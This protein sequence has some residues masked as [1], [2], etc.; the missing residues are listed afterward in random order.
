MEPPEARSCVINWYK[1]LLDDA[2][3]EVAHEYEVS[4]DR[5]LHDMS[6]RQ[7]LAELSQ[8][9]LLCAM[10][11]AL[12]SAGCLDSAPETRTDLYQQV[13][14]ALVFRR[15]QARLAWHKD[16]SM[17]VGRERIQV[18]QAIARTMT[19]KSLSV[20]PIWRVRPGQ[21]AG[22]V[23]AVDVVE[24]RLQTMPTASVTAHE[25]LSHLVNRSCVF[26][27][28]GAGEGQFVHRTFQE[29]LAGQEYAYIEDIDTLLD[30]AHLPSW[31][32]T[33]VFAA[34]TCGRA[35]ASRL[36]KGL[37]ALA[38]K[39][40]PERRE[41]LILMAECIGSAGPLDDDAATAARALVPEV[42]PPRNHA[43]GESI[44]SLGDELVSWLG[45]CDIPDIEALRASLHAC[46]IVGSARAMAVVHRFSQRPEAN[47]AAEDFLR[48][49]QR[50]DPVTY[51]TSVLANLDFGNRK[52]VIGSPRAL[53]GVASLQG[54]RRFRVDIPTVD[55]RFLGTLPDLEELD[56][57]AANLVTADG[58]D[59]VPRLERLDLSMNPHLHDISLVKAVEGLQELNLTGCSALGDLSALVGLRR[60]RALSVSGCSAVV[61]FSFLPRLSQLRTLWLNDCTI[62]SLSALRQLEDLRSLFA[63]AAEPI[64]E[65][66]D[67]TSLS[68]VRTVVR[69]C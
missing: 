2:D 66:G 56:C 19:D 57:R 59:G 28:V 31:R 25:A 8:T 15:D 29:F 7:T 47:E 9:P 13:V 11:S 33:V 58:I 38:A 53:P 10:L 27:D 30:H 46:G 60:L 62:T 36:V 39:R 12:Y 35:G 5:L 51:A 69:S 52:I 26:R 68:R 49:W 40:R 43:E 55:L 22:P 34:G 48:L 3:P 6:T 64:R 1:S 50:F 16:S 23:A 44:A 67:L 41:I 21:I 37:A 24:S 18:L 63:D 20:I 32:N 61:D 4:R 17:F 42:L 45:T 65:L 14:G 54:A